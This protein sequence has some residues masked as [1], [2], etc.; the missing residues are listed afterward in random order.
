VKV[1]D[2][3]LCTWQP[4]TS[5]INEAGYAV[6]MKHMIKGELGIIIKVLREPRYKILFPKFGYEHVLTDT[7][8]VLASER[9]NE[10]R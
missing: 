8:F 3:I 10:S 6:P 1:G 5:H 4:G 2:L 7:T 9:N